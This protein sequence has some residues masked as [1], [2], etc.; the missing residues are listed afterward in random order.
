MKRSPFLPVF[1]ASLGGFQF[2]FNTAI[3][4][5]AILFLA[6][7]FSLSAVYEGF[8]VSVILLGALLGSYLSSPLANRLGRKKAMASSAIFF[9]IG[10]AL[11]FGA[12]FA[13]FFSL[14]RFIQG[15]GVG[16]VSVICPM[17]LAE[18]A[19][20]KV[21]GFYVSCNQFAV[22]IGILAAYG[23]NYAFASTGNWR[24]MIGVALI[25]AALQL[26]AICFI[27]ESPSW[28]P[29]TVQKRSPWKEAFNPAFRSLLVIGILISI[30]QQVTGINAVI[31]FAPKI[32]QDAGY[33][34]ASGAILASVGI[35]IVNV[36]ATILALWLID[37]AG[38]RPLLLIGSAGMAVSLLTISAAFFTHSSMIDTISIYSLMAYIAFFAIGLGPMPWLI[39]S[40][41]YPLEIRG[42]AMGLATFANWFSNYLV[43]LTFLD[44]AEYLTTGGAFCIY[45]GFSLLAFLFI[46]KRL[47]ET[48][49]KTLE[50]IEKLLR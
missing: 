21:R 11:A 4:S 30:F 18:I 23:C 31:Y 10:T 38:R 43:A 8:A 33:S 1:A 22:T 39:L 20:P 26:L 24:L 40:E 48:K 3:I 12:P 17:Y 16:L 49:G 34:T 45:A 29:G 44:I 28:S 47:P 19:P 5:G 14:G 46:F 25:P 32:F 9:L 36:L 13:H 50:Q 35:G 37:K 15:I 27:P 42:Q 41:I 7:D 2:G 6:A